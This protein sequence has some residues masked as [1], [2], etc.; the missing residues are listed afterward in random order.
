[1]CDLLRLSC[2]LKIA[3]GSFFGR[4]TEYE[5]QL[6]FISSGRNNIQ[7]EDCT[8][9]GGW[10]FWNIDGSGSFVVPSGGILRLDEDSYLRMA[11]TRFW[12]RVNGEM[13]LLP[14]SLFDLRRD[15][16]VSGSGARVVLDDAAIDIGPSGS[17]SFATQ[18]SISGSGLISGSQVSFYSSSV[19]VPSLLDFSFVQ[20]MQ[21]S[22]TVSVEFSLE[23]RNFTHV[24]LIVPPDA[25]L[26][27][28]K[29]VEIDGFRSPFYC[30]LSGAE[31]NSDFFNQIVFISAGSEVECNGCFWTEAGPETECDQPLASGVVMGI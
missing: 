4:S 26:P 29:K 16:A 23:S 1:M 17:L 24:A 21:V 18:A 15:L 5:S 22:S 7:C 11:D 19:I 6:A 14:G 8:V 2:I 13:R 20:S 10:T 9:S 25:N 30:L 3:Q 12:L 27:C 31:R 28:S